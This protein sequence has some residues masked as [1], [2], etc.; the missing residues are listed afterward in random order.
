M[1]RLLAVVAPRRIFNLVR[2]SMP[3]LGPKDPNEVLAFTFDFTE[4][5]N[6]DET[7]ATLTSVAVSLVS[8]PNADDS[9]GVLVIEPAASLT[10]SIVTAFVQGGTI[11]NV[12]RVTVTVGSS[13]GCTYLLS[14][15]FPVVDVSQIYNRV[16]NKPLT[17]LEI[18]PLW[19][20]IIVWPSYHRRVVFIVLLL[21]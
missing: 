16:T 5:L 8:G 11:N 21:I 2:S 19:I 20:S 4:N 13:T 7:I 12:Y 18:S 17:H 3:I 9:D 10:D 15:D 14:G 1:E 6:G